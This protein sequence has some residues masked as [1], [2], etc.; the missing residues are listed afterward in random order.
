MFPLRCVVKTLTSMQALLV[1][2]PGRQ[3]KEGGMTHPLCSLR[4]QWCTIYSTCVLTEMGTNLYPS[5]SM[6]A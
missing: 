6:R 4:I 3:H 5:L 1:M 2:L